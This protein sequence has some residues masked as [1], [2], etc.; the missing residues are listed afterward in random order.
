VGPS[1]EQEHLRLPVEDLERATPA[2][3]T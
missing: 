1:L 3:R 2:T